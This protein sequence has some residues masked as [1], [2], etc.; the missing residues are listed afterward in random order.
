MT[1]TNIITVLIVIV[2]TIIVVV[3][4]KVINLDKEQ[5]TSNLF[6]STGVG[7]IV[8]SFA[9][10]SDKVIDII[11]DL[12]GS[13]SSGANDNYVSII[14]GFLL[15]LIGIYYKKNINDRFHVL[16]FFSKDKKIITDINVVKELKLSDFKLREHALDVVRMFKDGSAITISSNKYITEEIE[17]KAECF[18]NQ[19]KDF[20]R[21][22]TG[23]GAIPYT[24]LLGTYLSATEIDEYFEY[25]SNKK[26][27]Y[28]LKEKKRFKKEVDFQRL[29][30][31][32]PM[33][34][35]QDTE[36]VVSLSITYS[37]NDSDLIQFND[38]DNIKI[39]V[40][41]PKDNKIRSKEQLNN[42]VTEIVS[43]LEG[44]KSK[45]N[46]LETIHLVG[47]IPSCLSI[48]LGRRISLRRN[49]LLKIIS[50]QYMSSNSPRYIW[51]VIVTEVNKGKFI[52]V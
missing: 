51:G 12:V 38:K 13:N 36:V 15:I 33:K 47:A 44:L 41:T 52:K 3:I 27:Y 19:S 2:F 30:I 24:I 14:C 43:L 21:G 45:Y 23:M 10:K 40:A 16:N 31:D 39:E 17:E 46:N 50:Y 28:A 48:E 25:D 11:N 8:S 42:Y 9:T 29:N 7:L 1:F 32:I 49:R 4:S 18:I 35:I 34:K 20:K 22:F 37:V 6:I 26:K 5:S